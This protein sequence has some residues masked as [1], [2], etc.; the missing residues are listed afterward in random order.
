MCALINP[1]K[2]HRTHEHEQRTTYASA[3]AYPAILHTSGWMCSLF[4]FMNHHRW[5]ASSRI[6]SA[7]STCWSMRRI[8]ICAC[9]SCLLLVDFWDSFFRFSSPKLYSVYGNTYFYVR[10][11]ATVMRGTMCTELIVEW[12]TMSMSSRR[13]CWCGN[14]RHTPCEYGTCRIYLL[15]LATQIQCSFDQNKMHCSIELNAR[16]SQFAIQQIARNKQ[17]LVVLWDH[18][19]RIHSLAL[20]WTAYNGWIWE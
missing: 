11:A 1:R 16:S 19:N 12:E 4:S 5:G 6:F 13:L 14:I 2:T 15:G 9:S 20:S 3:P 8:R 7:K 17:M 18:L 10:Y